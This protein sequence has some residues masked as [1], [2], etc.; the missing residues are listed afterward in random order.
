MRLFRYAAASHLLLSFC[1][2][3]NI[4]GT[5]HAKCKARIDIVSR[6][7]SSG[8]LS[9]LCSLPSP[10]KHAHMHSGFPVVRCELLQDVRPHLQQALDG[11]ASMTSAISGMAE[12]LPLGASKGYGV[13]RVLSL[14]GI[15]DS[16]MLAIG[17]GE[18]DTE[19]LA[20]AGVRTGIPVL[21]TYV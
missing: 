18:N 5:V 16:E 9:W 1:N 6:I 19:L 3:L 8:W 7:F 11:K 20:M 17:D 4:P 10:E 14:L 13:S 15:E 21:C 12:V 2:M